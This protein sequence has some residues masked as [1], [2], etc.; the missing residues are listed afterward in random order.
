MAK[1]NRE[2]REAATLGD[3]EFWIWG[4][5]TLRRGG[6][7]MECVCTQ[8]SLLLWGTFLFLLLLLHNVLNVLIIIIERRKNHVTSTCTLSEEYFGEIVERVTRAQLHRLSL[9]C[10]YL[11]YFGTWWSKWKEK[12]PKWK[13]VSSEI[14]LS[15]LSHMFP[16]GC[17]K[18]LVNSHLRADSRRSLLPQMKIHTFFPSWMINYSHGNRW[19]SHV[20]Q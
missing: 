18:N 4:T 12:Y 20:S 9:L 8:S 10:R 13:K 5:E 7:R 11:G 1:T 19:K 14:G 2:F 17:A 15:L 6:N 3:L 16:H